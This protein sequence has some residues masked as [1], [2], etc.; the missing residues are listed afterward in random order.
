MQISIPEALNIRIASQMAILSDTDKP[1]IQSTSA[2]VVLAL[3]VDMRTEGP[4]IRTQFSSPSSEQMVT[5]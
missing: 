1:V 5:N 2:E 3:Y 4:G